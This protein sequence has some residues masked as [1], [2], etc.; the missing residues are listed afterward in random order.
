M[1]RKVRD[2]AARELNRSRNKTVRE[3]AGGEGKNLMPS[4]L[5]SSPVISCFDLGSAFV[6]FHLLLY[7]TQQKKHT[8]K[9]SATRANRDRHHFTNTLLLLNPTL[10]PVN[11]ALS[12]FLGMS[13]A[14]E[15]LERLNEYNFHLPE[16]LAIRHLTKISDAFGES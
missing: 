10:M 15:H 7:E 6:R 9:P 14:T 8:K 4:P 5:A 13:E 1:F 16:D 12:I 2:T 11:T 3:R